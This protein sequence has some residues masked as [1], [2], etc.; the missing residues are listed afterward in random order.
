MTEEQ[1]FIH[2]IYRHCGLMYFKKHLLRFFFIP[3][4]LYILQPQKKENIV[5]SLK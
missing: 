5:Q 1:I 2:S 3:G 4:F